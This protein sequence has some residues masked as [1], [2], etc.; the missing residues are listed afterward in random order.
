[1]DEAHIEDTSTADKT[2][3]E[4]SIQAKNTENENVKS[5]V[6]RP[7]RKTT[8]SLHKKPAPSKVEP[9]VRTKRRSAARASLA[10]GKDPDKT[11]H[12]EVLQGTSKSKNSTKV[13]APVKKGAP[14]PGASTDAKQTTKKA[15]P[16]KT[17][18]VARTSRR[19][20]GEEEQLT[21]Q[22][23]EQKENFTLKE[24]NGPSTSTGEEDEVSNKR[25]P[26]KRTGR[27]PGRKSKPDTKES[28]GIKIT[29]SKP[30]SPEV[31]PREKPQAPT[32][33]IRGRRS[34]DRSAEREAETTVNSI[35]PES[36]PKGKTRGRE[37]KIIE[38]EK[39]GSKTSRAGRAANTN[40]A[41]EAVAK[42]SV[43]TEEASDDGGQDS[44]VS[45][46]RSKRGKG[47]RVDTVEKQ[48]KNITNIVLSQPV[49]LT[50][51]RRVR[52]EAGSDVKPITAHEET[53]TDHNEAASQG[54]AAGTRATRSKHYPSPA[55]T[56]NKNLKPPE[57]EAV[58]S[59]PSPGKDGRSSRRRSRNLS[60][61]GSE[62]GS[63]N[64]ADAETQL[65][66]SQTSTGSRRGRRSRLVSPAVS[67]STSTKTSEET[68]TSSQETLS[69]T[70][71]GGRRGRRSRLDVSP[72]ASEST[73]NKTTEETDTSSQ[74]TL[75]Q[76]STRSTRGRRS[77][78]DPSPAETGKKGEKPSNKE[79]KPLSSSQESGGN[80]KGRQSRKVP[81]V[82]KTEI[83]NTRGRR[84][85]AEKSVE[86]AEAAPRGI[87]GKQSKAHA[88][89]SE[90][91]NQSVNKS[92]TK[93]LS[94]SS[95]F[96][97]S[98]RGRRLRLDVSPGEDPESSTK[99]AVETKVET[100]TDSQETSSQSSTRS[101]RGKRDKKDPPPAES[102]TAQEA[103]DIGT[104][105]QSGSRGTRGRKVAVKTE[106]IEEAPTSKTRGTRG[107]HQKEETGPK[108]PESDPPATGRGKRS[109][110]GQLL[111]SESLPSSSSQS[112]S[113]DSRGKRGKKSEPSDSAAVSEPVVK[114]A[115]RTLNTLPEEVEV[116]TET[117][118]NQ[119]KTSK[120]KGAPR[121]SVSRPL[122]PLDSKEENNN[123]DSFIVPVARGRR[124]RRASEDSQ[125]VR[126]ILFLFKNITL[127]DHAVFDCF[128][129]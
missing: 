12:D 84:S 91:N 85:A 29:I 44:T 58:K 102:E 76:T 124:K 129:Q 79:D 41:S 93:S 80:T 106:E 113:N 116:K 121:A 86:S 19:R 51:G 3:P 49:G 101:T 1:M 38:N 35:V 68:E 36:S 72:V 50:R 120:R 13:T 92:G 83:T 9:M 6:G 53:D 37:T 24:P 2:K 32:Q 56:D 115:R 123:T 119:S 100:E 31:S 95:G 59:P 28:K 57:G 43:H 99:I 26:V 16:N 118:I 4:P 52:H 77:R 110:R 11:G 82:E 33:T 17:G 39:A 125:T 21:E 90:I 126:P 75:S 15:T 10:W 7:G 114:R 112:K 87:R 66:A 111:I 74:E 127:R 27:S 94:P 18:D 20:K 128:S 109:T 40:R 96:S 105:S 42:G 14:A 54:A 60:P 117:G 108:V 71:T 30:E 22:S 61:A 47:W 73:L 88:P 34:K 46:T 64:A 45:S 8:S 81:P 55:K 67:E 103:D 70:S 23:R 98:T 65:T 97:S 89:S 122:D 104:S 5:P 48:D 107:K 69:Q 62:N 78:Q 63:T 25:T